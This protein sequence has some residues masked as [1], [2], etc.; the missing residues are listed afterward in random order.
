MDA[1]ARRQYSLLC[2]WGRG[3]TRND[4]RR[5]L[6]RDQS[7]I[8]VLCLARLLYQQRL[9]NMELPLPIRLRSLHRAILAYGYGYAPPL[10][11]EQAIKFGVFEQL[12][13]GPKSASEICAAC[14]AS[15]RGMT[16]ILN[17]LVGLGCLRKRNG[18]YRNVKRAADL[19]TASQDSEVNVLIRKTGLQSNYYLLLSELMKKWLRLGEA[20]ESGMPVTRYDQEQTATPYFVEFAEAMFANS[21]RAAHYFAKQ[22]RRLMHENLTVLDLGAGSAAWSLPWALASEHT[23]V[24][25]VDWEGVLPLCRD[26]S[27]KLGVESQYSFTP[28]DLV[29]AELGS[30][31]HLAFLGHVIHTEGEARS[32]RL[33]QRCFDALAPGGTIVVAEWVA[34]DDRSG[35]PHV[36]VF[37]VTMLLVSEQGDAFSFSEIS[38]WLADAGFCQ[39]RKVHV[40]APSPLILATKPL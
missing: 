37:A 7:S 24:T 10:I 28:G 21:F 6:T 19:F 14:G 15:L 2:R 40:P 34:D 1:R 9:G 4:L 39:I 25:A 32:R 13:D 27:A 38:T 26:I 3:S 11:L 5:R 16:M 8:C 33:I 18:V 23:R 12:N 35:P 31:Y 30:G 20:I 29:T 17:A 22:Q 36:M